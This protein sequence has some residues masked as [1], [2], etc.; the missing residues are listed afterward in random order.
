MSQGANG[1]ES[2]TQ[3]QDIE[4]QEGKAQVK[5]LMVVK[6]AI[7][8][9]TQ[10]LAEKLTADVTKFK[11]QSSCIITEKLEVLQIVG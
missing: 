8:F 6:V 3:E 4:P 11:E 7:E 1:L 10:Q 5:L 2:K 9:P